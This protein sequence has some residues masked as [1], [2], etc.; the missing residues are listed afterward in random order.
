MCNTLYANWNYW[1]NFTYSVFETS[2]GP[3]IYFSVVKNLLH[4]LYS[5]FCSFHRKR[6]FGNLESPQCVC[7]YTYIHAYMCVC[8]Y[9]CI[10][11]KWCT[12]QLPDSPWAVAV[13]PK[14]T[15]TV[16]FLHDIIC[17]GQFRSAVLAV[18]LPSF[19]LASSS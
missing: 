5:S 4:I 7:T 15:L 3:L 8:V 2:E 12:T 18:S 9:V 16:V 14:P 1:F 6:H 13:P 10:K 17:N 11:D 19:L